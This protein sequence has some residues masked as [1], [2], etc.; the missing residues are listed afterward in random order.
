MVSTSGSKVAPR[1]WKHVQEAP[2]RQQEHRMHL[3]KILVTLHHP[4]HFKHTQEPLAM[5][6]F[7]MT[8]PDQLHGLVDTIKS[9]SRVS[10]RSSKEITLGAVVL[11]S[12]PASLMASAGARRRAPSG[13]AARGVKRRAGTGAACRGAGGCGVSDPDPAQARMQACAPW[14]GARGV[15]VRRRLYGVRLSITPSHEW[16]TVSSNVQ[17]IQV[18][19]QS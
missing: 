11:A 15:G 3:L 9:C 5:D 6:S 1:N 17:S 16:R 4:A 8:R 10:M 14:R 19:A 12:R 2:H 18:S 13:D 7:W